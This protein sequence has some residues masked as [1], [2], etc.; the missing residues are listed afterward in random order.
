MD[1]KQQVT[2]AINKASANME[3]YRLAM[4]AAIESYKAQEAEEKKAVSEALNKYYDSTLKDEYGNVVR[5]GQVIANTK[6][7]QQYKVV[8]RSM[9]IVFGEPIWN[10]SAQVVSYHKNGTEGTRVK[11]IHAYE[12]ETMHVLFDTRN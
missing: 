4:N 2:E 5:V 3:P 10:P 7:L 6:R 11:N 1:L 12:L 8:G 9:Q